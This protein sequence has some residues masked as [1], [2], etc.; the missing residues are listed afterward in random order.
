[1]RST[2]SVRL[3][4]ADLMVSSAC[5]A[6][7]CARLEVTRSMSASRCTRA[8][9]LRQPSMP[10]KHKHTT[11]TNV[12]AQK[13]MDN[14]FGIVIPKAAQDSIYTALSDQYGVFLRAA[15]QARA[16]SIGC[17]RCQTMPASICRMQFWWPSGQ[18]RWRHGA[19]SRRSEIDAARSENGGA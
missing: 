16:T 11:M 12:V 7:E 8:F 13:V 1:M 5:W 19:Q 2:M 15:G 18:T 17:K 14:R 4:S 10:T 3:V 6:I 9:Q